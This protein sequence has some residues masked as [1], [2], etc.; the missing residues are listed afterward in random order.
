MLLQSQLNAT[1]VT[2]PESLDSRRRVKEKARLTCRLGDRPMP[3]LRRSFC[4]SDLM[5]TG[6]TKAFF[7]F[8]GTVGAQFWKVYSSRGT[9]RNAKSAKDP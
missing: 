5:C 4:S 3:A 8:L 7:A 2:A 9:Y 1:V 6:G